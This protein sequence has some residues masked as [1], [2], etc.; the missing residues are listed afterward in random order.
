MNKD[1]DRDENRL[2][3]K[4][5]LERLSSPEQ[6]NDY[7]KVTNPSIWILLGSM[8][9][10]LVGL[11]IWSCFTSIESSVS[12]NGI[13]E[14][15][16]VIISFGESEP[17]AKLETGMTAIVGNISTQ[18]DSVSRDASGH[19][20]ATARVDLPDG[21]YDVTVKYSRTQIISLLLN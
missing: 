3:R 8:I 7:L 19:L 4:K 5:S 20:I 9:I 11:I 18:V 21:K 15:G 14:K 1:Q 17:D 16:T 13:V 12:G 10:L 2:F 6:L